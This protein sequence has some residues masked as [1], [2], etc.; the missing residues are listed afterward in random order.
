MMK[1]VKIK[2]PIKLLNKIEKI[3]TG[4]SR[5]EKIVT[6]LRLGLAKRM[7]YKIDIKY[8]KLEDTL[9]ILDDVLRLDEITYSTPQCP[10]CQGAITHNSD[11]LKC[12]KCGS[13]FKLEEVKK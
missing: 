5:N 13:T 6:L 10:R 11:V 8:L 7:G 4:M 12:L 1:K 3:L 2:I 9:E